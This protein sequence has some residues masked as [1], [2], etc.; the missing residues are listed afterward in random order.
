MSD[1]QQEPSMEEI[2]ASIR[3]IISEDGDEEAPQE[4]AAPEPEPAPEPAPEPEPVP[5]PEPEPLELDDIEEE[6]PLE[7]DDIEE[8]EEPL[9]LDDIE[10]EPVEL[11]LIDEPEPEPVPEPEPEPVYEPAPEPAPP[12]PPPPVAPPI[13]AS[14]PPSVDPEERVVSPFTTNMGAQSFLH[15]ERAIRMGNAGDT[16]EG[17]VK[18]LLKPMLKG[19]LDENLPGLV[20]RLVE[21]EIQKMSNQGRRDFHEDNEYH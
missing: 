18:E 6:E 1:S 17:I 16:L 5:E 14:I 21:Q 20:E 8:E 7:L 2:L 12:P 15:L 4:A 13:A 19:W 9:E 10:E 3:K 11:E